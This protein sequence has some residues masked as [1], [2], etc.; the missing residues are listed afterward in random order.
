MPAGGKRIGAGRKPLSEELKTADLCRTAIINH[1]G[2]LEAGLIY[3]MQSGEPAL[4]KFVFEHAY[5]KP[6]DKVEQSGGIEIKAFWD[7]SLIPSDTD[8]PPQE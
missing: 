2:S 8:V 6:T 1:F 7:K 3:M 5:G 4:I